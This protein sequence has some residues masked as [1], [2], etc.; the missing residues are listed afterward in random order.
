MAFTDWAALRPYT[1]L[2]YTKAARGPGR[3]IAHEMPWN[4][5]SDAQMLRR[6][7]PNNHQM[8][9][10]KGYDE[11]MLNNSNREQFGASYYWVMDL[12]G[13]MWEKVITLG[14]SVG[15]SFDGLHGDGNI[16]YYGMADVDNWPSGY[17]ESF[18]YGYRGGGYYGNA[19]ISNFNPYSP[20][21]YRLYG[22]WSGGTRNAAYGYRAARTL[23]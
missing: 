19:Y 21:A 16:S 20:I 8:E 23:K 1:E 2:E 6:I 18:G 4:T 10:P 5:D 12:G 13:S 7:N 22:A 15:R 9:M 11:S 3:P 14:D 17:G